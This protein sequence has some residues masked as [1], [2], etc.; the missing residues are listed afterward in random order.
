MSRGTKEQESPLRILN[1]ERFHRDD[2]CISGT[3][4]AVANITPCVPMALPS[5]ERTSPTLSC[6]SH[7]SSAR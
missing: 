1:V 5:A 4:N 6:C 3:Q 7:N 2:L